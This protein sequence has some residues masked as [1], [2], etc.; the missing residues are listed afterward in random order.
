MTRLMARI[1]LL[2]IAAAILAVLCTVRATPYQGLIFMAGGRPQLL[3]I[4]A[5]DILSGVL[6]FLVGMAAVAGFIVLVGW[7]LEKAFR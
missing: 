4:W 5:A 1:A 2:L 7:L 3:I 6:L